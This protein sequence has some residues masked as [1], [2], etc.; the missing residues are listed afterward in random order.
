MSSL[1]ST[2]A[3]L[4]TAMRGAWQRQTLL[5]NNISNADT[6][7]YKREDVDFQSTLRSALSGEEPLESVQFNTEVSPDVVSPNG[8]GVSIDQESALLAENGLDYQTLTQMLGA[9]NT[10]L[11]AAMG[12]QT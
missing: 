12:L 11:L 9:E 3:I 5:T 10:T 7:G 8:N 4:A 6:A 1:D 2:Q